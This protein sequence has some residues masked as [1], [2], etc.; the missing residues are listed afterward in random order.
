MTNS[1]APKFAV[2]YG[3]G[4]IAVTDN[5][6][7]YLTHTK[8]DESISMSKGKGTVRNL[9]AGTMYLDMDGVQTGYNHKTGERV[10]L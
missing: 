8:F 4:K 1:P 9:I 7:F 6:L 10:D 5:R 3:R 2:D